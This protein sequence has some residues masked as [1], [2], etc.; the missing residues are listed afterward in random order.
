MN[1]GIGI[2]G[3][4]DSIMGFIAGGFEGIICENREDALGALK[5]LAKNSAIIFVTENI[6]KLIQEEILSYSESLTP[7]II[8]IPGSGGSLGIGLEMLNRSVEKAIG[9]NILNKDE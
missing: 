2:I 3:D 5:K 4:K 8:L 6:A 9:N 7:A 1:G